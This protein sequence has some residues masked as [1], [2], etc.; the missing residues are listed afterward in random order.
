MN[1]IHLSIA[2]IGYAA[3]LALLLTWLVGGVL[4][5]FELLFKPVEFD[6]SQ[7]DPGKILKKCYSLFPKEIV[8]FRGK[9]FKRGM[10]VRITTSQRKVIEG[11]LIGLNKDNMIC[12]MTSRYVVAHD[13]HNIEEITEIEAK[14]T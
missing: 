11:E 10:I 14:E 5:T 8:D 13:L 9:V 3:V 7:D 6:Y 1:G 12:L 4:R 2:D